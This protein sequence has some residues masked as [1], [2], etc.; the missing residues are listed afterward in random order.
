MNV[1][2]HGST[3]Q[4]RQGCYIRLGRAVVTL[5]A[6]SAVLTAASGD[7][8]DAATGLDDHN[9]ALLFNAIRHATGKSLANSRYR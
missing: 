7:L 2:F 4:R 3:D 9:T 5:A 1:S 8:R 6:G